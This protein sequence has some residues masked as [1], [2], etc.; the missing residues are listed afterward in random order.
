MTIDFTISLLFFKCVIRLQ[1]TEH[2]VELDDR[3]TYDR[4]HNPNTAANSPSSNHDNLKDET[5]PIQQ[6]L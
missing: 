2:V 5:E 3:L 6:E 4:D 1:I